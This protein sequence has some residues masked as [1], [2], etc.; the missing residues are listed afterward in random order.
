MRL[1]KTELQ[2]A[3]EW[4]ANRYQTFLGIEK[5]AADAFITHRSDAQVSGSID[6]LW[7]GGLKAFIIS[8]GAETVDAMVKE[9]VQS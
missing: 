1:T 8:C 2:I 6:L 9:L 5:Q 7:G 4:I 3:R